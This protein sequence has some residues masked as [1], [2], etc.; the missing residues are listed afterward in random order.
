MICDDCKINYPDELI[1]PF[2]SQHL[3]GICALNASNK[4]VGWNRTKFTGTQAERLR[5]AAIK[6][7]KDNNLDPT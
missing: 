6:F 4:A 5:R 7:R 1:Q 2:N 3:C